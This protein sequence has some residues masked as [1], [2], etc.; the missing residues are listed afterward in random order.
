MPILRFSHSPPEAIST[1]GSLKQLNPRRRPNTTIHKN[2][3]LQSEQL[4][5]KQTNTQVS[6]K[7]RRTTAPDVRNNCHRKTYGE[8]LSGKKDEFRRI[9]L[10]TTCRQFK[11]ESPQTLETLQSGKT[12][13]EWKSEKDNVEKQRKRERKVSGKDTN[14]G[15]LKTEERK[16]LTN[17]KYNEWLS[18]KH[19]DELRVEEELTTEMRRKWSTKGYIY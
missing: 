2:R 19:E 8:W 17:K 13:D 16:E 15:T 1:P 18:R 7:I 9:S 3:T 4:M 12:F 5:E 11:S 6:Q 10:Q 14:K